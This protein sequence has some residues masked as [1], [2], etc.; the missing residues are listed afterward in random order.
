[1]GKPVK[2]TL[3]VNAAVLYAMNSPVSQTDIDNQCQ[4][5]DDNNGNSPNNGGIQNFQSNVYDS[6]FVTWVGETADQGYS[7]SIDQIFNGSQFFSTN[8][9]FG[10]GGRSGNVRA[11]VN[12]NI[13][14]GALDTYKIYFSIYPPQNGTAKPY[15]IDPKLQGNS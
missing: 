15:G 6:N 5:A 9:V 8:P 14:P 10:N 2:I 3:T 12:S 11:T 13:T 4:L 7:I 1:M